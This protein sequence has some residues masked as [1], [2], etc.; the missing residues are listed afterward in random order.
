MD[1]NYRYRLTIAFNEPIRFGDLPHLIARTMYPTDEQSMHY[2][3][4]RL[5]LEGELVQAVENNEIT[6]RNA[7]SFGPVTG[8]S[9]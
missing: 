7:V 6:V 8:L 5:N 4:A 1:K 3:V 2:G 9:A